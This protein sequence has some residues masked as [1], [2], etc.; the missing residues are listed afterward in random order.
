MGN[1]ERILEHET[2]E[3]RRAAVW[4]AALMCSMAVVVFALVVSL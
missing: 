1:L 2:E 3:R 4:L